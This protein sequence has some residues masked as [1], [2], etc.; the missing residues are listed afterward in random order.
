M[1]IRYYLFFSNII[2]RMKPQPNKKASLKLTIDR[3]S[4]SHLT[5]CHSEL[6]P[7]SKCS[8]KTL[9]SNGKVNNNFIRGIDFII[10]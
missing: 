8:Q 6:P 9:S 3:K 5:K 2:L 10:F 1:M 4:L 7:S